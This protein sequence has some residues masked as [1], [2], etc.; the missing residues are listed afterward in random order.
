MTYQETFHPN[1]KS[2]HSK[3]IDP[4]GKTVIEAYQD[5]DGEITEIIEYWRGTNVVK[6]R[7]KIVEHEYKQWTTTYDENGNEEN[8]T[9]TEIDQVTRVQKIEVSDSKTHKVIIR[10]WVN[11]DEEDE[12][13]TV[14]VHLTV[15]LMGFPWRS[16][17]S[18]KTL[19]P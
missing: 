8:T 3:V 5:D 4:E 18:G 9:Y 10:K 13:V 2:A 12:G 1:G 6:S 11:M 16:P 15:D 19:A 7:K 14:T 17:S